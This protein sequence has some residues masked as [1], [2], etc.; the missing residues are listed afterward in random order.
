MFVGSW[1]RVVALNVAKA[2]KKRRILDVVDEGMMV[3]IVRWLVEGSNN[4]LEVGYVVELWKRK[5]LRLS[6]SVT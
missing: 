4:W 1:A 2:R 6:A 5:R 3:E